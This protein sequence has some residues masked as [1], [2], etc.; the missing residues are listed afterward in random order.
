MSKI[1]ITGANGFVG[2]NLVKKLL[3]E[4]HIVRCLVH[5]NSD[6]LK[7]LPIEIFNGSITSPD[8]L[9]EAV[10]NIDFVIHSAGILRAMEVKTFFDVN[11]AGTANLIET[12]YKHN[13]GIKRFIYISSQAAMGPSKD[14]NLKD[15][16]SACEPVSNY[17]KSK[18][19]GELEVLKFKN[20]FPVTILRPAAIYGP[21]DKDMFAFFQMIKTG[22]F[23]I[24][25]GDRDSRI[26][27][28]FIND[29]IEICRIILKKDQ[30]KSSIYFLSETRDYTWQEVAE[31]IGIIMGKKPFCFILPSWLVHFIALTAE[32]LSYFF[33][34]E[35]SP[36]NT[37]KANEFCQKYWLGDPSSAEEELQYTFT[38]LESGAKITYNWYLNNKWLRE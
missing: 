10:K 1:L 25:S 12:V 34:R 7:N 21:H 30:L 31:K 23:P 19:M 37:D 20:K 29:L 3:T 38:S 9:P 32:N 27:L 11:Q 4:G 13:P 26:Q 36:F 35:A 24:L 2:T 28:C 17:G 14:L 15:P 5:R 33:K 16:A 22:I 18:Y 8:T 6:S